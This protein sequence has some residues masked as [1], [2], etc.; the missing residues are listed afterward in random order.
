M[1][2]VTLYDG[3][4]ITRTWFIILKMEYPNLCSQKSSVQVQRKENK[5]QAQRQTGRTLSL[6][7]LILHSPS[8]ERL[9]PSHIKANYYFRS[10]YQIQ[11]LLSSVNNHIDLP[12]NDSE[13]IV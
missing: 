10:A 8:T 3:I 1:R 4:I 7:P 9:M 11:M 5:F 6:H 12:R 13:P 2:E